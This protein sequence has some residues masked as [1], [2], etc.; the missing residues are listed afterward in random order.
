MNTSDGTTSGDETPK[1]SGRAVPEKFDGPIMT[2]REHDRPDRG[3]TL[4]DWSLGWRQVFLET[5]R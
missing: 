5:L 4:V 2:H 1:F 3:L